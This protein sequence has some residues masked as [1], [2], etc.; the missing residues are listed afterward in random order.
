MGNIP[1]PYLPC[2][3][4]LAI[5]SNLKASDLAALIRTCRSCYDWMQGML[6]KIALTHTVNAGIPHKEQTV[7]QWAVSE[8]RKYTFNTLVKNRAD[9]YVKGVFGTLL[10]QVAAWGDLDATD[11]LVRSGIHPWILE[12]FL[13]PLVFASE[14]GHE[15]IV[16]YLLYDALSIWQQCA[17]QHTT[18]SEKWNQLTEPWDETNRQWTFREALGRAAQR[19]H[20]GVVKLLC[21]HIEV[22]KPWDEAEQQWNLQEA[23]GRA[24]RGGHL[25]V[26][27]L[28]CQYTDVSKPCVREIPF[29]ITASTGASIG[30]S[31]EIMQT[32]FTISASIG[33]STEIMQMLLRLGAELHP[34]ALYHAAGQGHLAL[35]KDILSRRSMDVSIRDSDGRTPLHYAARQG[36]ADIVQTLFDHGADHE[37]VDN[38]GFTALS[39]AFLRGRDNVIEILDDIVMSA[40]RFIFD[41]PYDSA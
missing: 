18:T 25:G 41:D 33:G 35:V 4:W 15:S 32:A 16:R 26:V 20:L 13:P 10:H 31:T 12:N 17:P 1:S 30:E 24:A 21:Q 39:D 9:I 27:E 6:D 7:L 40:L 23:L 14:G 36:H 29:T 28:L 34:F 38:E 2:E 3:I 8:Q 19:G 5:G 37:A 22:S 11:R